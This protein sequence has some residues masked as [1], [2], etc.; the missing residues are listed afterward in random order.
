M[1]RLP[2]FSPYIF[3]FDIAGTTIGPTWYG[4][5]YVVGFVLGYSLAKKYAK[6]LTDWTEQEV[7]SLFTYCFLGVIL[8]GRIGYVLFYQPQAFLDNPA[9]LFKI[10]DGGMS[11]H[12][13]LLGVILCLFLFKL[14]FKK[15]LLSVTDFVAPLFPIGLF[16]GRIGNFINA[17]LWGRPTDLP[18]GV[19]FPRAGDIARHP[20][21]IYEALLEGLVLFIIIN[22]VRTKKPKLGV[23]SGLFLLGYGIARFT[24]EFFREPDSHLGYL[25]FNW[26]TMGQIL[27]IPMI[28]IGLFLILKKQT[29]LKTNK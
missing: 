13:G 4:L 24:V 11:F 2:E 29:E 20:S 18:W 14:K 16:F 8:G 10:T 26:L 6:K 23:L 25:A 12:G 7:E 28:I 19:I 27:T 17:E 21:P 1:L 5:M 15:K 3:K 9:F 22:L